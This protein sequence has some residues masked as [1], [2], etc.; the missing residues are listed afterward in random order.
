M[1]K[2]NAEVFSCYVGADL[3]GEKLI[4]ID[5]CPTK[6]NYACAVNILTICLNCLN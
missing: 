6:T 3:L 2:I 4:Q 5:E 1:T